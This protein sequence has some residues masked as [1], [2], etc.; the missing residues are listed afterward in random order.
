MN[1]IKIVADSCC[2]L[3]AELL[4]RYDIPV[5]P[6]YVS[7][8]DTFYKD[9]V[10]VTPKDIYAYFDQTQQTPKTSAANSAD[11]ADFFKPFAD[12]GCDIIYIGIGLSLSCTV[13]NARLAAEEF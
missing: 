4:A 5:L 1:K 8:G 10:D 12:E 7:L 6:L 9:G 11:F 2:D 3:P 13:T